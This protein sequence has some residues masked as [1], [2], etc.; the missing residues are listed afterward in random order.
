MPTI[1]IF[2][3]ICIRMFY[4]DHPPPHFFAEYQGFEANVA[5]ATGEII[6]GDLPRNAAR[7]VKEWALRHPSELMANW[8]RARAAQPMERI[9]GADAD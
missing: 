1:S 5:I 2:Y 6:A 4:N 9:A 7:I 8:E 3:G